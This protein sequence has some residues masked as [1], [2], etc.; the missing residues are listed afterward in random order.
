PGDDWTLPTVLNPGESSALGKSIA[1]GPD[2]TIVVAEHDQLAGQIAVLTSASGATW[3]PN[4][5]LYESNYG[6]VDVGMAMGADGTAAAVAQAG[7]QV[8]ALVSGRARAA[9]RNASAPPP[10]DPPAARDPAPVA[11]P[12]PSSQVSVTAKEKQQIRKLKVKGGCAK[13]ACTVRL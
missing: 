3:S 13:V 12:E 7:S 6:M 11:V 5:P 9:P 8:V 10:A 1:M 2:G 4:I